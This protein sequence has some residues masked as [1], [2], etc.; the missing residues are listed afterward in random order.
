[1]KLKQLFENK[2]VFSTGGVPLSE[3]ENAEKELAVSFPEEY[4]ELLVEYGAI[5]VGTHEI[6]AL[7]VEGYLNV[8]ELTKEE[9][10]LAPNNDLEQN[11]VIQ[12]IGSEGLLIVLDS[13]G[14]VYEY[15]NGEFKQIYKDFYSYLKM[16]VCV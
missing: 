16:E 9:R 8:I 15:A 12:N 5:S 13:E 4:K 14:N 2:K 7:G 1:M 10:Q 3:V 6:A 11:I